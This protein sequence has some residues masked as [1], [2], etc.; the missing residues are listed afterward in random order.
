[1]SEVCIRVIL[2]KSRKKREGEKKHACAYA[3][4]PNTILSNTYHKN[5]LNKALLLAQQQRYLVHIFESCGDGI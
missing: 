1:M 2:R 3:Q 5:K 4:I